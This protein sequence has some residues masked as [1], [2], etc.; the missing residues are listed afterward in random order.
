[1][2]ILK[3]LKK[4]QANLS[5]KIYRGWRSFLAFL[6]P[7]LKSSEG[8]DKINPFKGLSY[9]NNMIKLTFSALF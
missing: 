3:N 7:G 5:G 6:G 2:E 1:M 4:K 9:F 8:S